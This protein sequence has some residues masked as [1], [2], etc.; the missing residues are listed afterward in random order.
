MVQINIVNLNILD[1]I[2]RSQSVRRTAGRV[3]NEPAPC[4]KSYETKH[5]DKVT[6]RLFTEHHTCVIG[7]VDDSPNRQTERNSELSS[8]STSTAC[9]MTKY[10]LL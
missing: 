10:T 6:S 7:T 3:L 9:N 2:A 1:S 8:R 4:N 5:P